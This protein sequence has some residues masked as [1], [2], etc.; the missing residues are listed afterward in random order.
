MGS[1]LC[2]GLSVNLM[3]EERPIGDRLHGVMGMV[4][5]VMAM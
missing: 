5:V 4:V 2:A 1:R 3:V